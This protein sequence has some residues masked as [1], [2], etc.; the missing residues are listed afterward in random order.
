MV[1]IDVRTK[2]EFLRQHIVG[3]THHDIMNIMEGILPPVALDDEL[4]LYCE[5][6]NR[7]MMACTLLSSA[8]FLHVHDGGSIG[9]MV[10]QGYTCE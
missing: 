6:G 3:A 8:G 4:L 2:E 7:S 5:S 1:I 9:N 10:Q